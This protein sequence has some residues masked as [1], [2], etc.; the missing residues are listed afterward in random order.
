MQHTTRICRTIP[1]RLQGGHVECAKLLLDAGCNYNQ[2]DANGHSALHWAL[3]VRRARNAGTHTILARIRQEYASWSI[4]GARAG[5][6]GCL[7]GGE[8]ASINPPVLFVGGATVLRSAATVARGP[9]PVALDSRALRRDGGEHAATRRVALS[10]PQQVRQVRAQAQGAKA[11]QVIVS[12][13]MDPVL[14]NARFSAHTP[15]LTSAARRCWLRHD[16]VG[17]QPPKN[18]DA[19]T[20]TPPPSRIM[21][22]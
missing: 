15:S 12:P 20:P 11:R 14:T 3:Q 4:V 22:R 8:T 17:T 21:H 1:T 5:P 9:E 16:D 10:R 13:P 6:R 2:P 19:P 18:H 7:G